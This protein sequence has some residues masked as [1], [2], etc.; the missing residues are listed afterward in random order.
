MAN[1]KTMFSLNIEGSVTKYKRTFVLL[2]A[3]SVHGFFEG[4]AIGLQT[5]FYQVIKMSLAIMLHKWVEAL[6]LGMTLLSFSSDKKIFNLIMIIFSSMTPL[7]IL[8][9]SLLAGMSST[10]NAIFLSLAAGTFLYISISD[11]IPE[12]F[13][14]GEKLIDKFQFLL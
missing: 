13:T 4:I 2:L 3:L 9:G 10:I 7:G 14:S 1:I 5:K 8:L 6:S 12:E 11:I